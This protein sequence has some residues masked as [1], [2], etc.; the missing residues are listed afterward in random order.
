MRDLNTFLADYGDSHRN[1][2]NQW[3]HILCV[4]AIFVS[5][6]GLFWLIP[7]SHCWCAADNGCCRAR[8]RQAGSS[9]SRCRIAT[10]P[11]LCRLCWHSG[12]TRTARA[13]STRPS[14][15]TRISL[16]S[17]T[18]NDAATCWWGWLCSEESAI[19][20]PPRQRNSGVSRR[21]SEAGDDWDMPEIV[22]ARG[23]AGN[24]HQRLINSPHRSG[25]APACGPARC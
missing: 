23:R 1:P 13:Q 15:V 3:V 22:P 12:G 19:S 5:T 8:D 14:R 7:L 17:P 9:G 10:G 25:A 18:S 20:Q 11:S 16:S 4:P 21:G 6:L 2:V 24:V